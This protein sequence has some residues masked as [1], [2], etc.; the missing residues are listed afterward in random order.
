MTKGIFQRNFHVLTE[1]IGK[2]ILYVMD[3]LFPFQ[4]RISV[5]CSGNSEQ[6]SRCCPA[7]KILL[8]RRASSIMCLGIMTRSVICVVVFPVGEGA[9]TSWS[10]QG[11]QSGRRGCVLPYVF[12]KE[13]QPWSGTECKLFRSCIVL[14][15]A[16]GLDPTTAVCKRKL[17]SLPGKS[18]PRCARS[19]SLLDT[20][21]WKSVIAFPKSSK[22]LSYFGEWDM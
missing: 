14:Y 4:S 15:P 18:V 19:N 2:C 22:S 5:C 8:P 21:K 13:D 6:V 9:L 10:L 17:G 12:S 11:I 20:I 16:K 1:E 7:G 3:N